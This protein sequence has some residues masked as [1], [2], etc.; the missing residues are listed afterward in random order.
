[1]ALTKQEAQDIQDMLDAPLPE[2]ASSA[3]MLDRVLQA[4]KRLCEALSE[5]PAATKR[6]AKD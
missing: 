3:A 4:V 6:A 5:A 1:M 2:N